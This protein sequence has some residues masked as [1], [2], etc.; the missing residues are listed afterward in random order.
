MVLDTVVE[1]ATRLCGADIAGITIR[2]GEVYRYV[3]ANQAMVA[4]AELWAI[5][6]QR[7]VLPG[8]ASPGGWRSKA[9]SY[10]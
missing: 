1:T 8:R 6:R 7:T 10:T 4:D 3:A 5:H 2:E 9:G